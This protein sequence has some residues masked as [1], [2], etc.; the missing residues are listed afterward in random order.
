ML[1]SQFQN[2]QLFKNFSILDNEMNFL[3]VY[4]GV[5]KRESE[6]GRL[7]DLDTKSQRINLN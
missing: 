1:F 7:F 5:R 3:D 4:L 6:R 2:K